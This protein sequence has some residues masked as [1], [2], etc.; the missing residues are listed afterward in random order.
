MKN[1]DQNR[2][3]PDDDS[4][5]GW[6]RLHAWGPIEVG[7]VTVGDPADAV[8][9]IEIAFRFEDATFWQG[10]AI[11]NNWRYRLNTR[12]MRAR[13]AAEAP[14]SHTSA[15][16]AW[17]AS[18]RGTASDVAT[19]YGDRLAG[20][21]T[22][23]ANE[24]EQAIAWPARRLRDVPEDP[25]RLA[26]LLLNVDIWAFDEFRTVVEQE[27][28]NHGGKL[29]GLPGRDDGRLKLLAP[30]LEELAKQGIDTPGSPAWAQRVRRVA[31]HILQSE[32]DNLMADVLAAC[33]TG[34]YGPDGRTEA[35]R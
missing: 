12:Y 11:L 17:I 21:L 1:F 4:A 7:A 13:G 19:V 8:E 25:R 27:I 24:L 31:Q 32:R 14:L 22:L 10:A 15:L 20:L 26:D 34:P 33:R 23:A 28:A 9:P 35:D 29:R 6:Y 5:V 3:T 2:Y 18:T 16:R 30:V